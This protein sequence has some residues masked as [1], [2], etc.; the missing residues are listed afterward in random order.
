MESHAHTA[1]SSEPFVPP[2]VSW[3]LWLD[4]WACFVPA[5]PVA[6]L[7]LQDP[8]LD[9]LKISSRLICLRHS[10]SPHLEG[11]TDLLNGKSLS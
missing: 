8:V 3:H 2:S 4:I 11:C 9:G 5:L 7:V 6:L 10:Y 1:A